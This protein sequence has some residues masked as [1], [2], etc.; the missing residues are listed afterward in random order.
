MSLDV[1]T[2]NLMVDESTA[3]S[4]DHT[5]FGFNQKSTP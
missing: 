4:A 5:T 2:H 3:C 1:P